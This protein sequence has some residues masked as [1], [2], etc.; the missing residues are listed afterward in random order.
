MGFRLLAPTVLLLKP[1]PALEADVTELAI[2][3]GPR[4]RLG[5]WNLVDDATDCSG[6]VISPFIP[7]SN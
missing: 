7:G 2:D 4:R 1:R 3:P 5:Q 6:D